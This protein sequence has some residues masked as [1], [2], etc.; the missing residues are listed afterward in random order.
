[1]KMLL[2]G[3]LG[4]STL[5]TW[6]FLSWAVLPLHTSTVKEVPNEDAVIAALQSSLTTQGVYFFPTMPP[7]SAT[8]EVHQAY[9]DKYHRG[10]VGMIMYSPQGMDPMMTKQMIVGFVISFLSAALVAWFLSRSTAYAAPYI[11]RVSY[12]GMFGIFI[13]VSQ[14]L[15]TWNWFGEPNDW[16]TGWVIDSVLAWILAGFVI[17]AIIKQRP[18]QQ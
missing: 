12:C 10:P 5:F 14:N 1:M 4:G 3:L 2:A 17:A 7:S 6:G 11:R 13:A 8:P 9:M 18:V 16:A 15:M